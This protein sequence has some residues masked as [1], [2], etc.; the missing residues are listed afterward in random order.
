VD[1]SAVF[2]ASYLVFGLICTLAE[3][4][5]GTVE[6]HTPMNARMSVGV[7]FAVA[8]SPPSHLNVEHK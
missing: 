6:R 8:T 7:V 3:L 4:L 1:E 5:R 2:W